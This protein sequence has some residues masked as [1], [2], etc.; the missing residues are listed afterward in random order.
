MKVVNFGKTISGSCC[1]GLINELR[2]L[3]LLGQDQ[4]AMPFLLRPYLSD[5]RWAWRSEAKYLHILTDAHSGGD[6]ERYR[7]KLPEDSLALVCAELILGLN[8]LH[9]NRI[10]HHDLKPCNVLVTAE[11]HCVLA[12][13]GGARFMDPDGKLERDCET[14]MIVTAEYAAPELLEP[15]EDGGFREYDQ[16]V[17]YWSLAASVVSLVLGD[18]YLPGS[19]A[20]DFMIFKVTQVRTQMVKLQAPLE[21]QEFVMDLLQHEA[22]L[23]P[24]YPAIRGHRA[25][26]HSDWDDVLAQ[27][28]RAIPFVEEVITEGHGG[29][30]GVL[31]VHKPGDST[32]DFVEELRKHNLRLD[33]DNSYDVDRHHAHLAAAL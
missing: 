10:V 27:Q 21:L 18:A 29:S 13:F 6:L 22:S 15:L 5:A 25:S 19:L 11:G 20:P 8:H 16:R 14:T 24:V 7:W 26:H 17:D 9:R 28:D 4:S 3:H 32:A 1:R 31:N 33:V 2:V 12:D 23:R 30:Y